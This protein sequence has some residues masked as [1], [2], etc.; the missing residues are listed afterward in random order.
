MKK[1]NIKWII[2]IVVVLLI[3]KNQDDNQFTGKID[4]DL[5]SQANYLMA[6]GGETDSQII[7]VIVQLENVND[8]DRV[9]ESIASMGGTIEGKYRIG[10]AIVAEVTSNTITNIASIR[11]VNKVFP[12]R[13]Y[14]ITMEEVIPLI[15]AEIMWDSGYD[16]TGVKIAILD[17]GV[18]N[19]TLKGKV[20]LRK[21]FANDEFPGD[22]G[23]MTTHGTIA[24]SVAAGIYDETS[25]TLNGVAPGAL[26][27]DTRITNR[28]GIEKDS[29]MIAGI[30][31]A[32]DPNGDG[33]YSDGADVMSMSMAYFKEKETALN[34]A[35][36]DVV[37][38]GI[39]FVVGSVSCGYYMEMRGK[40]CVGNPGN[41][42]EAITVSAA[43]KPGIWGGVSGGKDYGDYIKPDLIA[44]MNPKVV[45]GGPGQGGHSFIIPQISG[46]IALLLQK[47]PT[48]TPEQ[49]R[50]ILY[51][52]STD[53]G[54]P[55]S[56][57]RYGYGLLNV[58]RFL[59][60]KGYC[61]V[62]DSEANYYCSEGDIY[63]Y[64][65]CGNKGEIKE[66]CQY[67]CSEYWCN[68]KAVDYVYNEPGTLSDLKDALSQEFNVE[69]KECQTGDCRYGGAVDG[70]IQISNCFLW[71]TDNSGNYL[72][73][74]YNMSV[75][76][77]AFLSSCNDCLTIYRLTIDKITDF[78]ASFEYY[79]GKKL[80][81]SQ[82]KD[83]FCGGSDY[84]NIE[85]SKGNLTNYYF[86]TFIKEKEEP[87]KDKEEEDYTLYYIIGAII[88]FIIIWMKR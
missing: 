52:T 21:N 48:L 22:F 62:D 13:T 51:D 76:G 49:I 14:G 47:D 83:T 31:W 65:N 3:L 69:W 39:P 67:G 34:L 7:T 35:I 41:T 82:G 68:P 86:N 64:D 45:I 58:G 8:L 43:I 75:K 37:N 85:T 25:G 16:G 12:D 32:A 55:G 27:I 29:W 23:G 72:G 79:K 40:E 87:K 46:A 24:A 30:N 4:K 18:D 19:V 5:M 80:V 17:T 61:P 20:I 44:F 15:D 74:I 2:I 57:L 63:W 10:R 70:C 73:R 28:T 11:G 50:Q 38:L 77:P 60:Y 56:D 81:S 84:I 66:T 33:D 36:T 42:K 88:F 26:I 54:K 59:D 71:I 78:N 1:E 9:A 6:V 53:L